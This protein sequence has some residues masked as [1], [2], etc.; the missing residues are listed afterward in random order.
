MKIILTEQIFQVNHFRGD[1]LFN[2]PFYSQLAYKVRGGMSQAIHR[3]AIMHMRK[4][5]CVES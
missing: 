1:V 2:I 3:N 5:I 4:K